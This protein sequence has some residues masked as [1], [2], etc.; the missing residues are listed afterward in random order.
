MAFQSYSC[1]R[2]EATWAALLLVRAILAFVEAGATCSRCRRQY[3]R[4]TFRDTTC[5]VETGGGFVITPGPGSPIPFEYT[6][7]IFTWLYTCSLVQEECVCKPNGC[8]AGKCDYSFQCGIAP[9]MCAG[10][11]LVPSIWA[12]VWMRLVTLTRA[13]P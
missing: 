12:C 2:W 10:I 5:S 13:N 3:T 8:P 7:S 6:Q 9:H 4:T 1:R 11:S